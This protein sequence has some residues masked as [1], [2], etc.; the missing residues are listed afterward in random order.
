M[1]LCT[2]ASFQ[3][4]RKPR[5]DNK[6]KS[7]HQSHILKNY[8]LHNE[9]LH[10]IQELKPECIDLPRFCVDVNFFS[11][12]GSKTVP[13]GSGNSVPA[14]TIHTYDMFLDIGYEHKD[15]RR[16]KCRC[17]NASPSIQMERLYQCKQLGRGPR[18]ECGKSQVIPIK[19]CCAIKHLRPGIHYKDITYD[20]VHS[21]KCCFGCKTKP[22]SLTWPNMP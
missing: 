11:N 20:Q 6:A 15:N 19:P 9:L 14:S 8:V 22:F 16:N 21:S 5:S 2:L 1:G 4:S 7:T 10:L 13:A 18:L 12:H 3:C 17:H